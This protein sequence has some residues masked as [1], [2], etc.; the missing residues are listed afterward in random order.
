MSTNTSRKYSMRQ[1]VNCKSKNVIYLVTCNKC[2]LQFVGSTSNEFKVRFRNH[3]S[4]MI[5]NKN[6]CEVAIHFTKDYHKI[7]DFEFVIIK[8]ILNLILKI[9]LMSVF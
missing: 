6:T 1:D 9:V 8:Q 7:S 3:E 5:T 2:N 4:A